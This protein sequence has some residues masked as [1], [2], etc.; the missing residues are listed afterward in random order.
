MR[1]I[2]DDLELRDCKS[3]LTAGLER[4]LRRSKE[5]SMNVIPQQSE[6]SKER[7]D[8]SNEDAEGTIIVSV[9]ESRAREVCV[10][11]MNSK[12]TS[13]LEI[14]LIVD[15]HSYTEV[16]TLIEDIQPH[17]ILLHD[18]LKSSVLSMKIQEVFSVHISIFFITRQYFD[19]DKGADMLQSVLV[20]EVDNDLIAKYTVLAGSFCLL[21]YIE[22]SSGYA[23]PPHSIRMDHRSGSKNRMY[24]D[25]K[26]ALNLELVRNRRTGN[27]QDS[28]FGVMNN[29]KTTVGAA[30]LRKNL[31]NPCT[32]ITTINL[33]LNVVESF[34]R[35]NRIYADVASF[36]GKFPEF[37]RMLSGLVTKPKTITAKTAKIGIDTL[38]YLKSTLQIAPLL[39]QSL[40]NL[41]D[42]C[43]ELMDEEESAQDEVDGASLILSIVDNLN[44]VNLQCVAQKIDE[45]LTES[46]TYTKN[47][48]EM[49][50]QE[51]FAI[52]PF[53]NGYLDVARKIFLQSVEDI[54]EVAETHA[55]TLGYPIKVSHN[56]SRGY[57]LSVPIEAL[58][59]GEYLPAEFIQPVLHKKT[60]SCSTEEVSS[61]SDRAN[62]S[63]S[64]ALTL[65]ND[66][67]Q[68]TIAD[69][70]RHMASIFL[71]VDSIALLDMI[72]SFADLVALS[73][74]SF[75]RPELTQEGDLKIKGGR[76]L[77][78]SRLQAF[79][80]RGEGSFVPN[81]CVISEDAK[82]I[83]VTGPNGSGKSTYIKTP[84]LIIVLAHIGCFVPATYAKIPIRD[85]V[86]T[87]IGTDDDM[88]HNI[89][90][91]SM[92]M[93]E[94][95]YILNNTTTRSIIIVD[96][97]GRG[98][99]NLDGIAIAFSV[100]EEILR[101]GVMTLFVTHYTQLTT[102]PQLYPTARNIH[103][104]SIFGTLSDGI[105]FLHQVGQG[106]CDMKSGYGVMMAKL[107]NFPDSIITDARAIQKTLRAT[108]P[109]L[110]LDRV[111]D[112][113]RLAV[114][115]I[116]KNIELMSSES[117]LNEEDRK[118]YLNDLVESYAP[119]KAGIVAY[120]NSSLE[121]LRLEEP[122]SAPLASSKSD[123]T[124]VDKGKHDDQTESRNHEG[125]TKKDQLMGA[126]PPQTPPQSRAT[127]EV[128]TKTETRIEKEEQLANLE[129]AAGE[130][131]S[132]ALA[133]TVQASV[134][135]EVRDERKLH[136]IRNEQVKTAVEKSS[137]KMVNVCNKFDDEDDLLKIVT[138]Q[139]NNDDVILR[140]EDFGD[141]DIV[142]T[143]DD[144]EQ[145]N[146]DEKDSMIPT[147]PS[148]SQ[149]CQYQYASKIPTPH[150]DASLF[151]SRSQ[152]TITIAMIA[153]SRATVEGEDTD[154]RDHNH[155][156]SVPVPDD[157]RPKKIQK[158]VD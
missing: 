150:N 79:T 68:D 71:L 40:L 135:T 115:N 103:L 125:P 73:N 62:E 120:V 75:V 121:R 48:Y 131:E 98:T 42:I 12:H 45:L 144:N 15:S 119:M 61:L 49:R 88:E 60:I 9:V 13:L 94:T 31:L 110:M 65:T 64:T 80:S 84:V 39:A 112:S 133:M 111:V 148:Q 126:S 29:T 124:V 25:R 5:W 102:L 21:K 132:K 57:F 55:I 11:K 56:N 26:S 122:T 139:H 101:R 10:A 142:E 107:S 1:Q 118:K 147:P 141:I 100:A 78:T 22:N 17:E 47:A 128:L 89:S 72:C 63:I 8:L 87:R 155:S 54:H 46:T 81:D 152:S 85:R 97:L 7:F 23:F 140:R 113:N 52:K 149:T 36:L 127:V 30:L 86:L 153:G 117:S 66:M 82:F 83:I 93:K 67:I 95:A 28:L 6:S 106:P 157:D 59:D 104:K 32:D 96:E 90:T 129:V 44:D 16:L 77:A 58:G 108:Y 33:R 145:I 114:A 37:E 69:V 27:K 105:Q 14:L 146:E 20:G 123:A 3:T 34:L 151:A 116:L 41:M 70:R 158:S 92:E 76:H 19:Q 51:C 137:T 35:C 156:D 143:N 38:I 138:N 4:S 53:A 130:I 18:G 24:I 43:K 134:V 109:V 74:D 2:G 154:D 50:H 91:F 136:E 99:S